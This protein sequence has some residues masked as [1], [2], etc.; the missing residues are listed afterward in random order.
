MVTIILFFTVKEVS[1]DVLS[2]FFE[3]FVTF[4]VD[5]CLVDIFF[6][7]QGVQ[8][9]PRRKNVTPFAEIKANLI[10]FHETLL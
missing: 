5:P 7:F 10:D 3:F 8:V 1:D 2:A 9:R 4:Y 6:N